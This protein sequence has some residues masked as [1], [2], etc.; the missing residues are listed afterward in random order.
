[1]YYRIREDWGGKCYVR[2][3]LNTIRGTHA[4]FLLLHLTHTTTQWLAS[5]AIN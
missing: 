3:T 5:M 2:C 1:M 4:R